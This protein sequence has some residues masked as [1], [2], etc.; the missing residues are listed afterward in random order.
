MLSLLR[1]SQLR[2]HIADL[3]YFVWQMCH[4]SLLKI[5]SFFTH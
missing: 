2:K 3:R 5:L 1:V 4:Y